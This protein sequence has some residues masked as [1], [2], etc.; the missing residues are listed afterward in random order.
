MPIIPSSKKRAR[1]AAKRAVR[2]KSV[3]SAIRTYVKK[4]HMAE[5]GPEKEAAYR[6]AARALDR[7]ANRGIIHPN[8][9]ARTK[10]RM[11]KRLHRS[12]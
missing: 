7:A 12:A 5:D 8:K 11:A 4:F 2:N 6:Q 3:R 1:Q 10:S 9:A